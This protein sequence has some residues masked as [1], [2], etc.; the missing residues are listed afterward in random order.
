MLMWKKHCFLILHGSVLTHAR[1]S[2]TFWYTE[3]RNSLP[4]N[5]VQ[6]LLKSVTVCKSYCKKFTGTFV[7]GPQ[8]SCFALF[9]CHMLAVNERSQ[10]QICSINCYLYAVWC[11]AGIMYPRCYLTTYNLFF[12][13]RHF[14]R[15]LDCMTT[16]TCITHQHR[17]TPWQH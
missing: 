8:C 6:K 2:E 1:W 12:I 13:C 3:V 10:I 17:Q 14:L 9:D 16:V 7:Y 15:Q 5:L 4:V 11:S